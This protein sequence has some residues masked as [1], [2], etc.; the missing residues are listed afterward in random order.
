MPDHPVITPDIWG[1]I[2]GMRSSYREF[3]PLPVRW[4]LHLSGGAFIC[5]VV[6]RH[7]RDIQEDHPAGGPEVDLLDSIC[8]WNQRSAPVE[9]TGPVSPWKIWTLPAGIW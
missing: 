2:C 7:F 6:C 4:S 5:Q 8:S 1:R 9:A 3:P